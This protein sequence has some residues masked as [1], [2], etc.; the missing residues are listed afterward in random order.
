[1]YKNYNIIIDELKKLEDE[2]LNETD[3]DTKNIYS[4]PLKLKLTQINIYIKKSLELIK[5]IYKY[6]NTSAKER[7]LSSKQRKIS[8]KQRKISSKQRKISSTKQTLDSDTL[9]CMTLLQNKGINS[10]TFENFLESQK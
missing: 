10:Q 8:S 9:K 6:L 7:K 2:C 5:K 1:L 4:H 3:A